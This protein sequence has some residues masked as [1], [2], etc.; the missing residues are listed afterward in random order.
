MKYRERVL[1]IPVGE[2]S[3]ELQV[4]LSPEKLHNAAQWQLV[5]VKAD[6]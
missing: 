2:K 4:R 3:V 1:T 6:V 5:E